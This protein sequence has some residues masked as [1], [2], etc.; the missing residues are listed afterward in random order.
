MSG[1]T[2]HHHHP[3]TALRSFIGAEDWIQEIVHAR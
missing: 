2:P 3:A 1:N